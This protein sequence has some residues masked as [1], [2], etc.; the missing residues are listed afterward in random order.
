MLDYLSVFIVLI[1]YFVYIL[2][3]M[4]DMQDTGVVSFSE[5]GSSTGIATELYKITLV[6]LRYHQEDD[7]QWDVQVVVVS[8]D[9]IASLSEELLPE[10]V[11]VTPSWELHSKHIVLDSLYL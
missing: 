1:L 11:Q 6:R 9:Q 4:M 10:F 3:T 8:H 2:L 5:A 7:E